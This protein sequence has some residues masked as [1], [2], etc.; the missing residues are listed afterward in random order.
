[1][2]Q[3]TSS[4]RLEQYTRILILEGPVKAHLYASPILPEE[5]RLFEAIDLLWQNLERVEPDSEFKSALQARLM[6]EAHREQTKHHLGI[7]QTM[8]RS[9]T[10]WIASAAVVGAAATLAGAYAYWRWN[11]ARQAA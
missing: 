5:K 10:P 7:S 4:D 8:R 2:T 9:R 3:E 6:E 1:M 11:I